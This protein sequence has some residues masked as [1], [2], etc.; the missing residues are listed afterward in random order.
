MKKYLQ[1]AF[2]LG[3]FGIL[4]SVRQLKSNDR[5][6]IVANQQLNPSVIPA[7]TSSSDSMMQN[8]QMPMMGSYKNGT[9]T[10]SAQ[11]AFYGIVQV[12]IV[13]SGG[14]ISNVTFLQYPNENS[15]S[16]FINNQAMPV[17]QQEAIQVQS[18]NVNIVSG[19]SQTS[20]AFITS[21][22][23]ALAQAK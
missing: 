6:A 19:A 4:V 20:Q 15:T 11:D 21:L 2:I 12:Q 17:L 3:A 13:V 5:P 16:R 23:D 10:G 14:R 1:I 7:V 18:A 9:Y 22:T 8:N